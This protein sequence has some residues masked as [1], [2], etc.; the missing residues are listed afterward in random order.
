MEKSRKK[1]LVNQVGRVYKTLLES[2]DKKTKVDD[3]KLIVEEL[4]QKLAFGIIIHSGKGWPSSFIGTYK[5]CAMLKDKFNGQMGV[6][7]NNW[8]W[9]GM[10]NPDDIRK[11]VKNKQKNVSINVLGPD[12]ADAT[13]N[14]GLI[15]SLDIRCADDYGKESAYVGNYKVCTLLHRKYGGK[16]SK[17][18]NHWYWI[19]QAS[20]DEIELVYEAYHEK[21]KR[22]KRKE[23]VL[24]L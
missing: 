21:A 16:M 1:Q 2:V 6:L 5:Q 24:N 22:F 14:V 10:S 3:V 23:I 8:Y 20:L 18:Y 12:I 13:L 9:I 15:A 11:L 19:G 17:F 4:C 7:S